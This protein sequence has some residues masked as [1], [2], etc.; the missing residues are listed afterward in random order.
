M[1]KS[2]IHEAKSNLS[3]LIE[4]AVAGEEVIISKAGKPVARLVPYSVKKKPR[5]LG[6]LK[7]QI[8]IAPDFDE[9]PPGLAAAFRGESE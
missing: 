6:I 9:L 2:N 3:R 8:R 5:R 7:G 1:V 4:L